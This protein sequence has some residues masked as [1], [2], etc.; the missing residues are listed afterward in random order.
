MNNLNPH[1]Q[2]VGFPVA[3]EDDP[4]FYAIVDPNT[5]KPLGVAS[6]LRIDPVVG[7]IEFG[8]VHYSPQLQRTI[9]ATEAMYLL[10]Q[11]AF[12]LG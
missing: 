12:T 6:Y 4:L 9:A 3:N 5:N 2:P 8:H 11:R 10:M 7:S 1:G